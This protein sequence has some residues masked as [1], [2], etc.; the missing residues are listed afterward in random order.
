MDKVYVK[1]YI[2]ATYGNTEAAEYRYAAM[3]EI[4]RR[5]EIVTERILNAL[6][7]NEVDDPESL[8]TYS[9]R[10]LGDYHDDA[11]H[12]KAM[13]EVDFA[14]LKQD[15]QS[16]DW[17]AWGW[18]QAFQPLVDVAGFT[19]VEIDSEYQSF[20]PV[21]PHE[22]DY[23]SPCY[24]IY[25]SGRPEYIKGGFTSER[26]KSKARKEAREETTW[27]SAITSTLKDNAPT[28]IAFGSAMASLAVLVH[29]SNVIIHDIEAKALAANE[30]LGHIEDL[31]EDALEMPQI[32]KVEYPDD[33]EVIGV[34]RRTW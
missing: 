2:L 25:E 12:R 31:V 4:V 11:F 8:I 3:A 34:G 29:T 20:G 14:A 10:M 15:L 33:S 23:I 16:F 24:R 5:Y 32:V 28:L 18:V 27:F 19:I 22:V 1:H 7:L 21:N 30:V 9:F 13:V 26:P 17:S 6:I